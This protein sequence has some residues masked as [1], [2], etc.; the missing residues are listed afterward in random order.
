MN[1]DPV[2]STD[3]PPRSAE[4]GG[5]TRSTAE[6]NLEIE[7]ADTGWRTIGFDPEPLA[8]RAVAATLAAAAGQDG[9]P[10]LPRGIEIGILLTDDEEMKRLNAD[11]RK[12]DRSTNVLAFPLSASFEELAAEVRRVAPGGSLG[13]GDVVLARQTVCR[14][15]EVAEEPLRDHLCHL[16]AHGVLHLLGFDHDDEEK[17][18]EMEALEVKILDGL[19]IANPYDGTGTQNHG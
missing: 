11:Y 10:K 15:A 8:R 16:I 13:L 17:A 6:L 1:E 4:A 5:E 7:F 12:V 14:E 9:L 18:N 19:G 2:S 3:T